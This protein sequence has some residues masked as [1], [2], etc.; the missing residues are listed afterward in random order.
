MTISLREGT[1]DQLVFD[2][3]FTYNL[4]HLPDSFSENDIILDLGAH[5]GLFTLAVLQRGA[6]HVYAIESDPENYAIAKEHLK[7]Y[8]DQGRVSLRWQAVWR[9]DTT[10]E[11]TLYCSE[12]PIVE[13]YVNTG[14]GNVIWQKQGQ[15][16][17]VLPFDSLMNEATNN[18]EKRIRLLKIDCEGSEWPILFTS[19]TLHL[20]DEI[21]G[22]YHE[23]KGEY[24]DHQALPFV[25]EGL[26]RCTIHELVSLLEKNG[27]QVTHQRWEIQGKPWPL[28][29]FSAV[30]I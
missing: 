7:D 17:S 2:E 9:S 20:V 27:F 4:Y 8:I 15:A 30:R 5:I 29:T 1:L 13:N 16:V 11:E 24:D 18:G 14:A 26:E 19:H 28:G 3:V 25:I 23:I 10:D 22:E 6:G 12:Y 21:K